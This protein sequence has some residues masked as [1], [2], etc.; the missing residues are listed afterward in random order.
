MTVPAHSTASLLPELQPFPLP[1]PHRYTV[2]CGGQR[3]GSVSS[4]HSPF[5]LLLFYV[6]GCFAYVYMCAPLT[7]NA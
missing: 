3:S 1:L 4:C 7:Y 2:V 5:C 6:Y